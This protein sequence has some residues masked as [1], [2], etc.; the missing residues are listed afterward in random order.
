MQFL[1]SV[2]EVAEKCAEE[3]GLVIFDVTLQKE[4]T[5]RVLRI[6]LEGDVTLDGCA[7]V[8]RGVSRWIDEQSEDT[9]PF[10]NYHLE[11]S[12]L[13]L[14]RPLR[15][16][17]DFSSQIGKLCRIE[18]KNKDESGRRR[19]KGRIVSAMPSGVKIYTEEESAEFTIAYENIKKANIEIEI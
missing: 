13:G 8:S 15:N 6:S 4:K 9:V 1:D 14:D 12:S 3:H 7:A 18:T 17:K 2:R 19:Y 5:G 11:V 16:E 10:D